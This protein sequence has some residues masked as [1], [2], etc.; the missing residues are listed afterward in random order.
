MVLSVSASKSTKTEKFT[1]E[2]LSEN[3][4]L[5]EQEF[6][7]YIESETDSTLNSCVLEIRN[8]T[9]SVEIEYSNLPLKQI[10]FYGEKGFYCVTL[11]G[12]LLSDPTNETVSDFHYMAY[13]LMPQ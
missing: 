10:L 11:G 1:Y 13:S 8:N 9:F 5:L 3:K 4:A 12:I 7:A 2:E 6:K